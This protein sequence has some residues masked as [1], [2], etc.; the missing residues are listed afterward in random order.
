MDEKKLELWLNFW[1][2]FLGT[3]IIGLV[4]AVISW[5]IQTR[6]I[7]LKDKEAEFREMERLGEFVKH[8]LSKN[9]AVRRRFSQYFSTVTRSEELRDRWKEYAVVIEKEFNTE[10]LKKNRLSNLK[11]KLIADSKLGKDVREELAKVKKALTTV[12]AELL[13]TKNTPPIRHM[14]LQFSKNI[15]ADMLFNTSY[16]VR[17]INMNTIL[18]YSKLSKEVYEPIIK[19]FGK[20]PRIRKFLMAP[21]INET[22]NTFIFIRVPQVPLNTL[23]CWIKANTN[24]DELMF[25]QGLVATGKRNICSEVEKQLSKNCYVFVKFRKKGN[26]KLAPKKLNCT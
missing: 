5:Q 10:R 26:R 19:R 15:N 11:K 3:F 25:I 2:I 8:A 4:S 13:V 18:A 1:K 21:N 24:F 16:W 22:G 9:V 14:P 6:E 23:A 7:E 17:H 20:L 12:S